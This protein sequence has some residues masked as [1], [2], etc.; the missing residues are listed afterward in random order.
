MPSPPTSAGR[1]PPRHSSRVR[2]SLWSSTTTPTVASAPDTSGVELGVKFRSSVNGFIKGIGFYKGSGNTG[3]HTGTLWT[4]T[5]TQ[6]ATVTLQGETATGWQQANLTTSVAITAN[7][8]YV[9]S[10]HAPAGGYAF[11]PLYFSSSYTNS[12]LRALADGEQ[13]GNGV[14]RYGNRAFPTLT[15]QSSNYWVD[16][17]FSLT[18]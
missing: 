3:T 15:Y 4:S 18:P 11:D 9:V 5:G 16:V 13:G 2:C 8:T 1:L 6:L 7:T 10:Y 14:Y 17:V 12:P